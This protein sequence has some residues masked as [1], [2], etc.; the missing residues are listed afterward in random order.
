MKKSKWTNEALK[1]VVDVAQNGKT[2]LRNV[3]IH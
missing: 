3:N 2:P 1:W